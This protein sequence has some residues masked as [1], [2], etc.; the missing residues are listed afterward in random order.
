MSERFPFPLPF[1]WFSVGRL[2]E[3]PTEPVASIRAQAPT[4]CCGATTRPPT[5]TPTARVRR[6]LPPPRRPPRRRGARRRRLPRVPVPRVVL[7]RRRHQRR[8]PLRRAAQP[9][10][11]GPAYP[12]LVR[13]GHLLFWH[14]PDPEVEPGWDDPAGRSARATSRV[15]AATPTGCA[16]PGRRSPRTRSTWRTSSRCTASSRSVRI[17]DI[18]IDGPIRRVNSVQL[19]NS[20]AATSRARSR[21]PATARASASIHFDLMGHVTLVSATTPIDD[22]ESRC[23]SPCITRGDDRRRRSAPRFAA[24]VA[25]QF[26]EDIPIWENK[27]YQPSPALA[28]NEKPVTEFRRW[29][30]QFYPEPGAVPG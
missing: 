9:Q 26:H 27:R 19:F 17:G 6:L 14:H 30:A 28:P 1:G 21:P 15:P 29:A 4:S 25:R 22:D 2:D 13:N 12:T 23:A 5:A 16:R 24:E 18:T 8:H 11:P 20:P 3:L 10:G 7:P